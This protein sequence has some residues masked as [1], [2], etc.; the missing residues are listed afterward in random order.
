MTTDPSRGECRDKLLN[1]A[2]QSMSDKNWNMAAIEK[3]DEALAL[4]K[5]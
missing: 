4:I 5:R 1:Y 3:A 2:H